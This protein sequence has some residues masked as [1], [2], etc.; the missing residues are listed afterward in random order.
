MLRI[1]DIPNSMYQ[2]IEGMSKLPDFYLANDF[3]KRLFRI[4]VNSKT[5]IEMIKTISDRANADPEEDYDYGFNDGLY[6]A[7]DSIRELV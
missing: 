1:I 5:E 2:E 3:T 6:A 7:I 4:I